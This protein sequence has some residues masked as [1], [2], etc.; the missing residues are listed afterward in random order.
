[1]MVYKMCVQH[2]YIHIYTLLHF[3]S[4]TPVL[5]PVPPSLQAN[6]ICP[7]LHLG[8]ILPLLIAS[9][10]LSHHAQYLFQIPM[11]PYPVLVSRNVSSE[12]VVIQMTARN[13]FLAPQCS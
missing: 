10:L 4:Q 6:L 3:L 11:R 2:T 8:T 7:P 1:M 5:S 12:T 9:F 13:I